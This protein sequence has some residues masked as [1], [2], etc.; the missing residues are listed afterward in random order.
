MAKKKRKK[1]RP[2]APDEQFSAGPLTFSRFGRFTVAKSSL[3]E[4]QF[5]KV[6]RKLAES[7]PEAVTE[8]ESLVSAVADRIRRLPPAQLLH[9]AWW[10][11]AAISVGLNGKDVDDREQSLA[12]RLIDYMQSVIASARPAEAYAEEISEQEWAALKKTSAIYFT[13]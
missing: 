9:R 2:I 3:D 1:P 8:V 7:Y 5:E 4:E 12:L 13:S 11:F 10:E 6:Q